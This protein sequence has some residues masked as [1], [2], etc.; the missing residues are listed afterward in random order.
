M[1]EI[2]FKNRKTLDFFIKQVIPIGAIVLYNTVYSEDEE[3]FE[4]LVYKFC[5]RCGYIKDVE[6]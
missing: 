5:I 3:T 4:D 6:M 2:K 1:N